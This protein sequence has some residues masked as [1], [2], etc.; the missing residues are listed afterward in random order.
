MVKRMPSGSAGRNRW[1]AALAGTAVVALGIVGSGGLAAHAAPADV[2]EGLGRFLSGSVAGTDLDSIL[3]LKGALAENPGG[4]TDV[5]VTAGIDATALNAIG[6]QLGTVDLLGGNGIL[7]LGA[8]DQRAS[9]RSDGDA[10]A[11][12]GALTD[13]GAVGIDQDP[14]GG[15]ADAS[16]TLDSLLDTAGVG[17]QLSSVSL[18]T[19]ALAAVAAQAGDGTPT[20]DYLIDGLGLTLR[21][22]AVSGIYTRVATALGTIDDLV[23]SLNTDL[24]SLD[25]DLPGVAGVSSDLEVSALPSLTGLLP[26]SVSGDGVTVDLQAGT[27]AVD[28]AR[29]QGGSLNDL[30]PNTDILSS[31]VLT[32]I[33][34]AAVSLITGE[35]T[36]LVA[37]VTA[38][39]DALTISGSVTLGLALDLGT[40]SVG[41]SGPITA[42][43]TTIDTSGVV[44]VVDTV[45][46]TLG[47]P[48]L[49]T[50]TSTV[51]GGVT[52]LIG[53]LTDGLTTLGT[54]IDGID[55]DLSGALAPVLDA[56]PGVLT[57]TAN[58]QPTRPPVNGMG[59][60]GA[61]SFTV[62]AL[63][64]GLL[65]NTAL[66]S[67][68]DLASASVRGTAAA[69]PD[70]GGPVVDPPGGTQ[71]SGDPDGD[72]AVTGSDDPTWLGGLALLLLL[73]GA[74]VTVLA[75]RRISPHR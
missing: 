45:L 64:I 67:V 46:Q 36:Q 47:L 22:N 30:D 55:A 38:A 18:G 29:F 41:I 43:V 57:L 15:I 39:V 31:A 24:V 68:I 69:D 6:I 59:D 10:S 9:A 37:D 58:V 5:D 12:S 42:P 50:I 21:S 33:V 65:P 56:L 70:P 27:I 75:H 73:A 26:S 72:L 35:L 66:A 32:G 71:P 52:A 40:L 11:G 2:S 4:G 54:T 20:T 25:V 34:S 63:S 13:Q 7:T 49:A 23:D 62:R 74:G 3:A 53:D 16:L 8:V 17:A 60:L 51:L 14:G 61:G 48:P 19:G 44:G 28:L 1:R